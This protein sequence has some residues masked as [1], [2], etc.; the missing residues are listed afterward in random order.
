MT[1]HSGSLR[2]TC[3]R[4]DR[5]LGALGGFAV[6]VG[7]SLT[8]FRVTESDDRYLPTAAIAVLALVAALGFWVVGFIRRGLRNSI[9]IA[10][11][12]GVV[13]GL[14]TLWPLDLLRVAHQLDRLQAVAEDLRV[15]LRARAAA[16]EPLPTR[17]QFAELPGWRERLDSHRGD[18]IYRPQRDGTFEIL[19]RDPFEKPYG[20]GVHH[21]DSES[22]EWTYAADEFFII[23]CYQ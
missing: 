14:A 5:L 21:L 3:N 16:G 9:A 10:A 7:Y 6:G 23:E 2:I 11:C 20:Y 18:F 8:N 19:V 13:L 1:S 17:E 22:G 15:T 12:F 4:R